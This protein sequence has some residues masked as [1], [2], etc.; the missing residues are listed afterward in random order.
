MSN[1]PLGQRCQ[2]DVLM[3]EEM[4]D[5][6][7]ACQTLRERFI[8]AC[9]L[10][11]GLRVGELV[12]LNRHWIDWDNDTITVPQTQHCG[13]K[14]CQNKRDGVWKPKSS[15]SSRTFKVHPQLKP[16]LE[17]YLAGH[18]RLGITRCRVW[19][20]I[21]TLAEKARILHNVYPHAMRAT[22]ATELAHWGISSVALQYTFGW[23][24]LRS[25]EA[26]VKSD[27]K[28]AMAETEEIYSRV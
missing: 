5:M 18:D 19:Q 14:E 26:Y 27:M 20:I 25:A 11:A 13:C 7:I 22:A 28:R 21:K 4:K 16:V 1:K 6:L 10:F 12:H 9:L 2:Q 17:E 24:R 3:S 15:A 23:A 8:V